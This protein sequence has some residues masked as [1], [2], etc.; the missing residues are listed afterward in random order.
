MMRTPLVVGEAV[1]KKRELVSAE[2]E[3]VA[4]CVMARAAWGTLSKAILKVWLYAPLW[5]LA[6]EKLR[7]SGWGKEYLW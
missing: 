2:G 7:I 4:I 1:R 3:L 5:M 6:G